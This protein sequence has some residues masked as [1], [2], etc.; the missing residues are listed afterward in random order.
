MDTLTTF[1]RRV[2]DACLAGEDPKLSLLRVQA[3]AATVAT[4]THTGVGAYIDFSVPASAPQLE[5][6][7]IVIGD[8]NLEISGVPEGVATLLYV[9]EGRLQFLEFAT[10]VGEWPEDPQ[11]VSLCYFQE[12]PIGTG[13]DAFSLVPVNERHPETLA[14]ALKGREAQGAA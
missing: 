7:T 2:L 9:Y 13:T 3:D 11:L 4:R 6:G 1:E 10:Y 12:A 14:R 5:H 8:V